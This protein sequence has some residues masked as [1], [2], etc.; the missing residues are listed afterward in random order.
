MTE[1]FSPE[2]I[3]FIL[4]DEAK[5][6]QEGHEIA[7]GEYRV[8]TA[9]FKDDRPW[10]VTS[11]SGIGLTVQGVCADGSTLGCL[12]AQERSRWLP[13]LTDLLGMIKGKTSDDIG[14]HYD[15]PLDEW[16]AIKG[17]DI[18]AVE[19]DKELAAAKLAVRVLEGK[20]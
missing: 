10:I 13:T 20:E 17:G 6:L 8:L 19:K 14:I 3:K 9:H 5:V 7:V 4:S 12:Y 2:Y 15:P 1:R 16:Y 11:G 18:I